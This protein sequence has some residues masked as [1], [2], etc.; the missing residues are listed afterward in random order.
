MGLLCLQSTQRDGS[1]ALATELRQAPPS[2]PLRPLW[3][4]AVVMAAALLVWLANPSR[5]KGA[6]EEMLYKQGDCTVALQTARGPGRLGCGLPLYPHTQRLRHE[7]ARREE[8]H[9]PLRLPSITALLDYGLLWEPPHRHRASRRQV[10]AY[11]LRLRANQRGVRQRTAWWDEAG[12]R[13]PLPVAG[14]NK[15]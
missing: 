10:H 7:L 14:R 1:A 6:Q 5:A 8:A 2:W 11:V 15:E 12:V 4:T 13:L 9:A 3:C